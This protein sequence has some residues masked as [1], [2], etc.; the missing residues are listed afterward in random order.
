MLNTSNRDT[1]MFKSGVVVDICIIKAYLHA[2][3]NE[4]YR[5]E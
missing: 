2:S 4:L 1:L 5:S 3:S